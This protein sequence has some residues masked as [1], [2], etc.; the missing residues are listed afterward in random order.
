MIKEAIGV[1]A[2]VDDARKMAVENL[3]APIDA[4]VKVEKERA[5]GQ[6]AAIRGEFAA[7]DNTLKAALQKEI[8]KRE[9][10]GISRF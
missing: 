9:I 3:H 1:A 7:A 6:E 5:E 2:N 4:D 8:T 10:P